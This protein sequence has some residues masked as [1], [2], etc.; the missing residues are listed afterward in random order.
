MDIW[1]VR[2]LNEK[3]NIEYNKSKTVYTL[4]FTAIKN[5]SISEQV[6][7]YFKQRLLSKRNFS[8][9]TATNYL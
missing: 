5:K 4:D 3:Y 7:K 6:K 8:W 9:G 2:V 1:D